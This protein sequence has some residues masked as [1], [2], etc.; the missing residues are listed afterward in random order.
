MASTTTEHNQ[1]L[2]HKIEDEEGSG[3]ESEE[4]E[5]K[6]DEFVFSSEDIPESKVRYTDNSSSTVSTEFISSSSLPTIPKK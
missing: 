6:A 3:F 5:G 2:L 4:L 1:Y